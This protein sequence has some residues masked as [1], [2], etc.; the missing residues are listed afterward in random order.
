MTVVDIRF[1]NFVFYAVLFP[2]PFG[3]LAVNISLIREEF[4]VLMSRE[5]EIISY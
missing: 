1:L 2:A 3:E 4:I 5:C